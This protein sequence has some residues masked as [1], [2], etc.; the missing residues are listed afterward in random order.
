MCLICTLTQKLARIISEGEKDPRHREDA[1]N[2]GQQ[3]RRGNSRHLVARKGCFS[4]ADGREGSSNKQ[5]SNSHKD[6]K[7]R[8]KELPIN[9]Q[10]SKKKRTNADDGGA[11]AT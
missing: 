11:T 2:R 1:G 5:H 9:D 4:A 8:S 3:R 6:S 7:Q 10:N